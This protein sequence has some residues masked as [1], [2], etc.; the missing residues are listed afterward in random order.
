MLTFFAVVKGMPSYRSKKV[1]VESKWIRFPGSQEEHIY[2]MSTVSEFM[3]LLISSQ[4]VTTR[5]RLAVKQFGI[6][7]Q[8][9]QTHAI[10]TLL[11]WPHFKSSKMEVFFSRCQMTT[12]IHLRQIVLSH[13][14]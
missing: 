14:V 12:A 8:M 10:K 13:V 11:R 1:P 7:S 9:R 6:I 5:S 2:G 4:S 3:D